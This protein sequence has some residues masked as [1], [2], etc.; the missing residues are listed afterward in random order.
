MRT[1]VLTLLAATTLLPACWGDDAYIV[2]GTVY[3]KNSP[4]RIVVAH[5]DIP[6]LMPAMVMPFDVK[7]PSLLEDVDPGDRIYARLHVEQD[8]SWLYKVRVSGQGVIPADYQSVGTS[9]VLPGATF[10]TVEVPL[11]N[12]TT[13]TLGEGQTE[14]TVLSYAYT[15]CPLPD[16]CPA[17]MAR[18]QRL[19]EAL[20]GDGRLLA[21]TLDP[22]HDTL[23]A[24]TEYGSGLGAVDGEW[25]FGRV[26]SETLEQLAEAS[27]LAVDSTS[28]EILHGLRTVIIAADGTVIERYDDN[29]YPI[30]RVVSQVRTGEP[31]PP[32]GTE[33]TATPSPDLE[34][35]D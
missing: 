6:G 29:R 9:A 15:S 35:G 8:G 11:T 25:M 1:S 4:T 34:A 14:T 7:D 18:F 16:F 33:G 13:W 20:S 5:E 2:E 32:P 27:G 21:V 26:D 22:E 10:P 31:K 24:L 12:G 17:T 23:E 19:Q 30:E 3:E 28:G